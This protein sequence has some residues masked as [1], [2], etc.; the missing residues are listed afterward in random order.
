VGGGPYPAPIT[1]SDVSLLST[2]TITVTY[3]PTMLRATTV[4]QGTFMSQGG[5]SPTFAPKIDEASGR[6]DIAISR[7]A[8]KPGATI[9]GTQLL[10]AVVFQAL[11]PGTADINITGVA[12]DAAGQPI[13][14]QSVPAKVTV[15]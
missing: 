2:V 14:L 13:Q 9:V 12:T 5:V 3:D 8:D 11:K 4:T 1:I 15:K 10:A 6:I 7:G